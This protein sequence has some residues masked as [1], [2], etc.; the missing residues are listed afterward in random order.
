MNNNDL[1]DKD[2]DE[3]SWIEKCE[4]IK[5]DPV[6][7]SRY[8]DH[9]FR[10]FMSQILRGKNHPLGKIVDFF[11]RV[12]FQQ[13]GSPHIHLLLWIEYAP[14]YGKATNEEIQ[15]IVD[16]HATCSKNDDIAELVNYQTHRHSRTCKS[17]GKNICRFNFPL[18]PLP[19]TLILEPLND[20]CY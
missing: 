1:S 6:T 18:P 15:N 17:G 14:I 19:E 3:L 7:C 8:F 5:K 13:R 4:L 2:V 20:D 10:M 16:K 9:R 11:Y 12:E